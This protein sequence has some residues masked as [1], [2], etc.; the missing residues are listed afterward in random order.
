ML[1]F[2]VTHPMEFVVLSLS[3]GIWALKKKLNKK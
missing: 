2:S 1:E 3:A